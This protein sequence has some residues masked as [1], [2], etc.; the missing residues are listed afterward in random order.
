MQTAMPVLLEWSAQYQ[1]Y[2][3]PGIA[4]NQRETSTVFVVI[5][6]GLFI[7]F[8]FLSGF[9]TIIVKI[10]TNEPVTLPGLGS[11]NNI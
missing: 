2:Y 11:S 4:K 1:S 3:T 8:I 6:M 10:A 9:W 5:S 7:L